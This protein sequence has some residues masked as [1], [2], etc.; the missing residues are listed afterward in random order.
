[1]WEHTQVPA[2]RNAAFIISAAS[3]RGRHPSH[4]SRAQQSRGVQEGTPGASIPALGTAGLGQSPWSAQ[5]PPG[6]EQCWELC[7][8]P[9]A[10]TTKQVEKQVQQNLLQQE[11]PA[12]VFQGTAVAQEGVNASQQYWGAESDCAAL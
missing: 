3:S 7:T 12:S 5:T 8:A 4:S 10:D 9:A 2:G 6:W 11:K 1:M